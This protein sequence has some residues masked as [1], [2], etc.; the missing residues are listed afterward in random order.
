[1]YPTG[2][3]VPKRGKNLLLSVAHD[4]IFLNDLSNGAFPQVIEF[5]VTEALAALLCN[6]FLQLWLTDFRRGLFA[7][8]LQLATFPLGSAIT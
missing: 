7:F 5:G 2:R 1:M 8:I 6:F 4:L 3:D